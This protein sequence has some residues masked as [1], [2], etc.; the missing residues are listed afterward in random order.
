MHKYKIE[1]TSNRLDLEELQTILT[2]FPKMFT[3]QVDT[4]LKP[5]IEFFLKQMSKSELREYVLECPSANQPGGLVATI[6]S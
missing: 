5:T 2:S 4:N 3:L 6:S 1:V